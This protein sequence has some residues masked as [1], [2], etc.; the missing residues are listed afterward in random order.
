MVPRKKK[1][2]KK[3]KKQKKFCVEPPFFFFFF[4]LN[5]QLWANYKQSAQ[6]GESYN[7]S[8]ICFLNW[9]Y[10]MLFITVNVNTIA[11]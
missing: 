11:F 10:I 4:F 7:R 6:S 1:K 5:T 9:V 8:E 3:K 2:K